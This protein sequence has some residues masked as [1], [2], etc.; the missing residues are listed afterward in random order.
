VKESKPFVEENFQEKYILFIEF[1][2]NHQSTIVYF[3]SQQLL[4]LLLFYFVLVTSHWSPFWD[5]L[6]SNK[7]PDPTVNG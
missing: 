4:T 1:Q 6:M 5:P 7:I 3:T 2:S